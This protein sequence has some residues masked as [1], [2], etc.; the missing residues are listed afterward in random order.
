M[1]IRF[2][3][4]QNT[5]KL[6]GKDFSYIIGIF[7]NK[8]LLHLYYG[9]KVEIANVKR[10]L[11]PVETSFS[12]VPADYFKNR[13]VSLDVLP[14]EYPTFGYGDFRIPALTVKQL[15]ES[16]CLDLRYD[17]YSI[18]KGKE[19][20]KGMPSIKIDDEVETLKITLKDALLDLY[21]DLYYSVY[22]SRNVLLRHSTIRNSSNEDVSILRALSFSY[23]VIDHN[24]KLL[25]LY[26]SHVNE[27]QVEYV[28][29]TYGINKIESR[30]GL[31]SPQ[32]NPFIA[33]T[34]KNVDENNGEVFA[35]N[36]IYSGSFEA[37]VEVDQRGS[38]RINMGI[39]SFDFAWNL[40]QSESFD[41]PEVVMV[42][43]NKGLNDMSKTYHHLYKEL[44]INNN[45]EHPIVLNSW[46]AA[47]FDI[48]ETKLNNLIENA[49]GLGIEMF[50][51]DDGWFLNR[52]ND[53]SSLG[54][55]VV[56]NKK[57]PNGLKPILDKAKEANMKLGLWFEPE[58]ISENS[59]LYR[60]HPEYAI[61]IKNR[62]ANISRCQLVLDLSKKEVCDYII[63]A[64][65]NVVDNVAISYIKW[66]FN[67]HICDLQYQDQ[68]HKYVLGLYYVLETLTKKYPNVLI[69]GCSGGGGRFDP[70][71][72]Y[73]SPQIW[74]SDNT[75]AIDRLNIQYGTSLVYPME[76]MVGHVSITPNH[77]NGRVTPIHTRANVAMFTSFGYELDIGKLASDEKAQV[78][79][80]VE[81][82]K[83][84][85]KNM[86]LN[87][88]FYRLINPFENDECAFEVV[89]YNLKEVYVMYAIKLNKYRFID[90]YLKLVGLDE[91]KL[92]EDVDN[93]TIYT[94]SELMNIGIK[95]PRYQKDFD[96]T[97][98]H[99]IQK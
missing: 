59:N 43:S 57:L 83:E 22:E 4:E 24:Y 50:V 99:F 25:K 94:G 63:D 6:D 31:S 90:K 80:Q 12:P 81:Y 66:D 39:S 60:T 79:G 75:D 35:A 28:D 23:D 17:S 48:N 34:S 30:R 10:F 58:M 68:A 32:F 73:Y 97:M 7:D 42:Y 1:A 46:E 74:T 11:D 27:R 51:I 70:A 87:S 86:F 62:P 96:S 21:V 2:N 71:I 33:L 61:K 52:N 89:S 64:V 91:N 72:L 88:D 41:T 8:Y 47:Y 93:H 9:K 84:F 69:E 45:Y 92:Y 14:Q 55:W 67:R 13:T 54:D 77:L 37:N 78:K 3:K 85:R 5:F 82:Y 36:L 26:G 56:D 40:K 65:S 29:L 53:E 20:V 15:D 38:T 49:K 76:C 98:Y 19:Q 44:L 95:L 16:R 18:F